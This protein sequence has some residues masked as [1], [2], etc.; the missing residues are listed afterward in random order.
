MLAA[1]GRFLER[2]HL[3]AHLIPEDAGNLREDELQVRVPL[4]DA[5]DHELVDDPQ[6]PLAGIEQSEVKAS[7]VCRVAV[8]GAGR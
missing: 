5:E 1:D 3:Q 8:F 6:S 4:E 2:V 7:L